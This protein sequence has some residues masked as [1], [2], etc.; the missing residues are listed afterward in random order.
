MRLS[1]NGTWPSE[2]ASPVVGVVVFDINAAV[3]DNGTS[4]YFREE[5]FGASVT[6]CAATK[7]RLGDRVGGGIGGRVEG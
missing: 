7:T 6:Y 2:F 4:K 5:W 3:R 1:D